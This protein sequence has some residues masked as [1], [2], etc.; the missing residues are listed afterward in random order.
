M[1][2]TVTVCVHGNGENPPGQPYVLVGGAAIDRTDCLS[3]RGYLTFSANATA[4]RFEEF[5]MKKALFALIALILAGSA[6]AVG[7]PAAH[8]A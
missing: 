3:P 8:A 5:P 2:E 6:V 1:S 7:P 4:A